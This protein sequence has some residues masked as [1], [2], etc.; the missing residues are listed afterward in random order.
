[1]TI[2]DIT[3]KQ[4]FIYFGA[5][6]APSYGIEKVLKG[7]Q[8]G[9]MHGPMY[10]LNNKPLTKLSGQF[11]WE[12]LSETT[13]KQVFMLVFLSSFWGHLGTLKWTQKGI[14]RF[15]SGWHIWPNV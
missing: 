9:G 15:A 8:V 3:R 13:R 4:F 6:W 1:M 11:F 14:Q 10:K 5:I 2:K 12:K 7:L